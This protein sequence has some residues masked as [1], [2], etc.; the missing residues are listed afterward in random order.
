[1]QTLRGRRE[2]MELI[3]AIDPAAEV[4]YADTMN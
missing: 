2:G 1:M 4:A 3:Y